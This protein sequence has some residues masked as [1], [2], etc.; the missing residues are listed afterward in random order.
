[1]CCEAV[2]G[3]HC[4]VARAALVRCRADGKAG[5]TPPQGEGVAGM[6]VELAPGVRAGAGL[7]GELCALAESHETTRPVRRMAIYPGPLP[8]D[9]R[10]NAKIAR[11]ALS[12][13]LNAHPRAAWT[14]NGITTV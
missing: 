8:T 11:E 13:W 3:G 12:D 9:I 10:H 7:R 6:V 2:F 14:V 4:G 1:M 5:P